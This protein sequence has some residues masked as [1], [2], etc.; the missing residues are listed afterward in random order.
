MALR[1]DFWRYSDDGREFSF[2]RR[3]LKTPWRNFISTD[4]LKSVFSHTGSGPAF[5]RCAYND[6]FLAESN[7]RLILVRDQESGAVW[8]V[9]GTDSA[10]QPADWMCTHGFGYTRIT[11]TSGAITGSVTYFTPVDEA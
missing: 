6:S 8:T 3:D 1:G 10:Q 5:G 11:S 7:P 4:K 2:T 9:N